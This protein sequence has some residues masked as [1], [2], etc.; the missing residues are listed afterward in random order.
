MSPPI[1]T[2]KRP[3]GRPRNMPPDE[4]RAGIIAA[5]R[6]LFA[7]Y[8]FNGTTIEAV[9]REAGVTRPAVYEFFKNKE[10]L[11]VA[12]TDDA[13]RQLTEALREAY[14]AVDV[15]TLRAFVR[16]S[17]AFLFEFIEKY[18]D[19]ATIIRLSDNKAGRAHH[20]IMTARHH[21]EDDLVRV[22]E[23]GWERFGGISHEAARV[24]ALMT[25]AMVEAVG[26]RQP[27]EPRWET[28]ATIEL[29]TD[30]IVGGQAKLMTHHD[31]LLAFGA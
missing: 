13:S 30:V 24:L 14:G 23:V 7:Q 21:I 4:Q 6:H 22:Y 12:V 31:Q 28:D 19:A 5:A 25:L 16:R 3:P 2:A 8:D 15:S 29:L 20:E 17:V 18:P 9:A 11:F 26:F 1:E 27:N 10:E